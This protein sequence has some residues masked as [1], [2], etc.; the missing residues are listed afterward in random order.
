MLPGA[1]KNL[2]PLQREMARATARLCLADAAGRGRE[3][4]RLPSAGAGVL[5]AR[6]RCTSGDQAREDRGGRD[7]GN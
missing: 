6:L 4:S 1:D 5:S 3:S 7:A 2:T